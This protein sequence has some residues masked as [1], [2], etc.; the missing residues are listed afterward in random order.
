VRRIVR[1]RR[2]AALHAWLGLGAF[3]CL[4]AW[5]VPLAARTPAG[6]AS[7]PMIEP[8]AAPS[9]A[10]ESSAAVTSVGVVTE[11][12]PGPPVPEMKRLALVI[13][14]AAYTPPLRN[15][16]NDAQAMTASLSKVGWEVT[17]LTNA[18]PSEVMTF[19]EQFGEFVAPGDEV[20]FYYSGHGVQLG[21][22]NFLLPVGVNYATEADVRLQS[23]ALASL[24]EILDRSHPRSL[25]II[26]DACRDNPFPPNFR[27]ATRGGLRKGLAAVENPPS[28]SLIAFAASEGETASDGTGEHGTFTEALLEQLPR[29]Y[30]S[31]LDVLT[32]VNRT[33]RERT[34]N[35]QV[36]EFKVKLDYAFHFN[37][38][39]PPVPAVTQHRAGEFEV[40]FLDQS[41]VYRVASPGTVEQ[42]VE[43]AKAAVGRSI[44]VW[45]ETLRDD[46]ERLNFVHA[47]LQ[48]LDEAI[49]RCRAAGS[50]SAETAHLSETQA[51]VKSA[52]GSAQLALGIGLVE[53]ALKDA[54]SAC[55]PTDWNTIAMIGSGAVGV[56]GV[57]GGSVLLYLASDNWNDAQ[58]A[59]PDYSAGAGCPTSE[60]PELSRTAQTQARAATWVYAVGGAALATAAGLWVYD[61]LT[62]PKLEPALPQA[63]L[64]MSLSVS[65][66]RAAIGVT[67]SFY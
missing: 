52:I 26:L 55:R 34:N 62:Q 42:V 65:G 54:P 40:Q 24:F 1:R 21:G 6:T 19:V 14:N 63:G 12:E 64:Q 66:E 11:V 7:E 50:F 2:D 25:V 57:I 23:L 53:T 5:S 27:V 47:R 9:T 17:T 33:V 16:L 15:P 36:P 8:L 61:Y 31:A 60:G 45:K 37:S 18:K 28:R 10:V 56:A 44:G 38:A 22:E 59:C 4:L 20:V 67:G 29:P 35:E 46:V 39:L 43:L 41:E 30:L 32:E 58:A 49:Q 13:G 3:G 48:V 51:Q